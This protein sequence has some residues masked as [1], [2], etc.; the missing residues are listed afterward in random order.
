ARRSDPAH[1]AGESAEASPET[2]KCAHTRRMDPRPPTIAIFDP[3]G[4]RVEVPRDAWRTEVLPSQFRGHWNDAAALAQVIALALDDGFA[5]DVVH[6]AHRLLSIDKNQERAT[7]LLGAV[8]MQ[9]GDLAGA[10][11]TLEAYLTHA[12]PSALV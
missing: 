6:A 8:L 4:R 10:A 1:R 5:A 2:L 11:R 3:H 12:E 7:S 9:N